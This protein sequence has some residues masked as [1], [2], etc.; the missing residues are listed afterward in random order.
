MRN[1]K[2]GEQEQSISQDPKPCM[3]TKPIDSNTIKVAYLTITA[4]KTYY[5]HS[6]IKYHFYFLSLPRASKNLRKYD[7]D[8]SM[9]RA[10]WKLMN[11]CTFR[12]TMPYVFVIVEHIR[13]HPSDD[14]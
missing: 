13:L 6:L 9:V 11:G 1:Y 2:L 8:K 4:F 5:K 7:F 3:S 10:I 12:Y 14:F